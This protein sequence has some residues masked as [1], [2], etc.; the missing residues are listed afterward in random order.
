MLLL[1]FQFL[2]FEVH[3]YCTT[4]FLWIIWNVNQCLKLV[5]YL[6]NGYG[7]CVH[8]VI[9]LADT[10]R[11][12]ASMI[13]KLIAE[14]CVHRIVWSSVDIA[15]GISA[16]KRVC[17]KTSLRTLVFVLAQIRSQSGM[18]VC[19]YVC[20]M[21]M[22]VSMC[23]CLYV[24]CLYVYYMNVCMYKYMSCLYTYICNYVGLICM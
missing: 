3:V 20:N 6:K 24:V 1:L 4:I 12:W 7:G 9:G 14:G 10:R 18:C 13:W 15:I 16:D 8:A 17:P 22:S 2:Y 5:C 11:H 19:L 23:V 21:C